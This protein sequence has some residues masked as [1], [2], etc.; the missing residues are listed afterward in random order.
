MAA[1]RIAVTRKLSKSHDDVIRKTKV[2]KTKSLTVPKNPPMVINVERYGTLGDA[3]SIREVRKF[4]VAF[5]LSAI[6]RI[7]AWLGTQKFHI[8]WFNSFNIDAEEDGF[9]SPSVL[10]PL[11][12]LLSSRNFP[13]RLYFLFL[14]E[15][16]RS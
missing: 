16:P 2:K 6:S 13:T 11:L 5:D 12:F 15:K 3:Y 9:F 8:K 4:W 10:A 14:Q 1:P 7:Q